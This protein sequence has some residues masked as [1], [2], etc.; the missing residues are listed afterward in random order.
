MYLLDVSTKKY[1]TFVQRYAYQKSEDTNNGLLTSYEGEFVG[2][3]VIG[4]SVGCMEG[5]S[6]TG[7][8][9]GCFVGLSVIGLSVGFN[10]GEADGLGDGSLVGSTYCSEARVV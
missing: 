4:F 6:V 3:A 8:E 1:I 7:L 5:L 2:L 9:V 10:E